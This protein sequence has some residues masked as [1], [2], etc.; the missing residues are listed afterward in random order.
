VKEVLEKLKRD[1]PSLAPHGVWEAYKQIENV[2]ESSPKNELVALVSLIRKVAGIDQ[3]LTPYDKTVD[4][5]FKDWIFQQNAGKHNKFTEE[6][7]DWL[8]MLK[9]HVASSF[10]VEIDDLDYNPFDTHGGRGKMWQL[11]E[12]DMKNIIANMNEIVAA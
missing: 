9:D 8:R 4:K 11:F 3:T 2:K 7:M 5:N 1:K 6:Q 10:H 12:A